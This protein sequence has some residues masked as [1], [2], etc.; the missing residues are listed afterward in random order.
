MQCR[1]SLNMIP[2]RALGSE[3]RSVD[4]QWGKRHC[5]SSA[6]AHDSRNY[7]GSKFM[8][9]ADQDQQLLWK[10]RASLAED[11]RGFTAESAGPS[12][13]VILNKGHYR[14]VWRW[15]DGNYAFTPGGYA[16]ST[17]SAPTPQEAVRFTLDHVC[18]Q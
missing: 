3:G 10:L 6:V 12:G 13:V 2:L 1:I 17:H 11:A 14:G 4:D 15:M 16:S 9:N 18:R 8:T 7:G 5:I